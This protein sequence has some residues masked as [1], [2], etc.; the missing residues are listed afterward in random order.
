MAGPNNQVEG[1]ESLGCSATS[2]FPL[3]PADQVDGRA[4]NGWYWGPPLKPP[5]QSSDLSQ[6]PCG[7]SVI[8][9]HRPTEPFSIFITNQTSCIA[10]LY[11]VHYEYLHL[12]PLVPQYH[13]ILLG[14]TS[15]HPERTHSLRILLSLLR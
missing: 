6:A 1:N 3:S 12:I 5:N 10:I 11:P 9:I 14:F 13:S 7:P 4:S 15:T 8:V 2:T